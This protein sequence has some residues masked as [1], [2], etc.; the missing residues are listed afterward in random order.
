MIATRAIPNHETAALPLDLLGLTADSRQVRPGFLF[1]ALPG[2]AADG[3]EFITEALKRGAVAVLKAPDGATAPLPEHVTVIED[4]NPRRRFAQICAAFFDRQP[5]VV[6]AVTG[7]NGKTSTAEF[8]RQIWDR[9]GHNSASL[10]TLGVVGP[11]FRRP[12]GLTTP[13]P[14]MLHRSLARLAASGIDRLAIEASSHGLAQNRLDGLR[15]KAAAFTSFSRD[16]LDYHASAR[17]YLDAKLRLFG[18]LLPPGAAAV[19]NADDAAAEAVIAVCRRRRHQLMT[20]GRAGSWLKL[21]S[22]EPDGDGQILRIALMGRPLSLRLPLVG[23]FQASNALAALGLAVATG[24]APADAAAA[25]ERLEG[26]PGRLQLATRTAAGAPVYVDYAHTPDALANALQA[27]RPHTRGRL[28]VVFGAGGDRDRGKRPLMGEA[29]ARLADAVIVTDDN[30]RSEPPGA[31]RKAILAGCPDAQEIGDR[32]AAIRAGVA[33]LGPNDTLL[34]AGKGHEQGQILRDRTI[35]F[36]DAE[37][38]RAAVR[39]V[40]ANRAAS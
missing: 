35:P 1:A 27:L 4:E 10:G 30:P 40:M 39:A 28:L 17:D 21:D 15:L 25:L 31:I 19:V 33:M 22:L 18:D 5:R 20:Y 13:D 2:T 24:A 38:A 36:D 11:G 26:V 16:H 12:L 32:A 34:I 7:T 8:A 29:A 3:R 14:V 23:A 9:L 6:A 37:A